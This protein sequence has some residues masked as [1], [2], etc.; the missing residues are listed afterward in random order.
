M[1]VKSEMRKIRDILGNF[2]TYEINSTD[3]WT[4]KSYDLFMSK[5]WDADD[6]FLGT[7]LLET[8][9]LFVVDGACRLVSCYAML[10]AIRDLVIEIDTDLANKM[11]EQYDSVFLSRNCDGGKKFFDMGTS[12]N[13]HFNKRVAYLKNAWRWRVWINTRITNYLRN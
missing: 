8:K 3:L 9:N 2:D 11:S 12:L 4:E 1:V 13:E 10:T 5:L 7:M 6:F